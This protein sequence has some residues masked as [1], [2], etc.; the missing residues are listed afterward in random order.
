MSAETTAPMPPFLARV[1]AVQTL[2][3]MSAAAIIILS[4][5]ADVV[6]RYGFG[7]PIHG[8]YDI[9]ECMLVLLVFHGLA[10][11]FIDRSHIVIDLID[12]M[13]GR[14]LQA[15]L[16]RFGDLVALAALIL[17]LWAMVEPAMQAY[18]YHDRKLELG[19]PVWVVW[20][21]A[22]TGIAG[23]IIC[24]AGMAWLGQQRR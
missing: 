3:S 8:A 9:V 21:F 18:A 24:A 22:T 13:V 20:A 12:H 15:G 23:A 7:R 1:R 16:V 6:L 14:R 5:T 11:V 2:I 19:L 17:M 4:T 10:A